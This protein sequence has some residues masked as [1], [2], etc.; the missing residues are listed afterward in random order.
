LKPFHQFI[1]P[2]FQLLP[3]SYPFED[4]GLNIIQ[5][6]V[7]AAGA[8]F[9]KRSTLREAGDTFASR[10]DEI[11]LISCRHRPC[12]MVVQALSILA[13]TE[14][15]LE[16]NN[17]GWTYLCKLPADVDDLLLTSITQRWLAVLLRDLV[18]A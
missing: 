1:P 10:A 16:S 14:F 6:A 15:S 13:W 17:C 7:F 11:A 4:T 2:S 9:S 8:V 18:C 3:G 12:T 5:Q